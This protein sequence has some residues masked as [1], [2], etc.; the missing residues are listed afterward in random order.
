[1]Y[2]F[3][4]LLPD[5]VVPRYLYIE[6]FPNCFYACKIQTPKSGGRTTLKG[7][8]TGEPGT[9]RHGRGTGLLVILRRTSKSATTVSEI[10]C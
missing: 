2:T 4:N 7:K 10:K 5:I 9:C 3:P 1:M 8:L 6:T